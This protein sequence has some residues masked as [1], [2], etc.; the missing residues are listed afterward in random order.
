[1]FPRVFSPAIPRK[2]PIPELNMTI[3]SLSKNNVE[4]RPN[5]NP[6]NPA[7]KV[8]I[9]KSLQVNCC[10]ESRAILSCAVECT[11][12]PKTIISAVIISGVNFIVRLFDYS[13]SFLLVTRMSFFF[14]WLVPP[15]AFVRLFQTTNSI[16][17]RR[18]ECFAL[19]VTGHLFL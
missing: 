1:M 10:S 3:T 4:A 13:S 7:I 16:T 9:I 8:K 11:T 17:H 6:A 19:Y 5:I 12:A 14:L 18:E 15:H 2:A